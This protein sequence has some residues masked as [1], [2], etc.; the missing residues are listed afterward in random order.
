ML[1]RNPQSSKNEIVTHPLLWRHGSEGPL[2]STLPTRGIVHTAQFAGSAVRRQK[3]GL[4]VGG[5]RVR[6]GPG[7]KSVFRQ[8][9]HQRFTPVIN[10]S[11]LI[12][13]FSGRQ[14][15]S[16]LLKGSFNMKKLCRP[17]FEGV[18]MGLAAH[19][20][21]ATLS[22]VGEKLVALCGHIVSLVAMR[23][24]AGGRG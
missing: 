14:T 17:F 6:A 19:L 3:G 16:L 10:L 22:V 15:S 11:A 4:R 24:L 13:D 2:Q 23:L 18:L 8:S 1:G 21:A 7:P 5:T 12:Q 9:I 20:G